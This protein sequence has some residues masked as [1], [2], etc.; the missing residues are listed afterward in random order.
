LTIEALFLLTMS[1][2]LAASLQAQITGRG[3]IYFEVVSVLL[4]V[5]TLGKLIG[6]R[7]RAAALAGSRAWGDRLRECRLVDDAGG[8]RTTAVADVQTGDVVEVHPGEMIAVD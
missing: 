3:K 6:E 7:S 1:G 5:Y 8:T 4:V 2:A